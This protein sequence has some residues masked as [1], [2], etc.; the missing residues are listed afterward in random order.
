MG[1]EM[2]CQGRRILLPSLLLLI[3]MIGGVQATMK[4]CGRKLPETLSKLCVYGFNAMTKRTL[5]AVNF[6]LID[7]FEDRSLLERLLSDSSVQ[8]LKTRRL[9]DGVF[10]ECCLKSCTMDEVLRYCAAKPRTITS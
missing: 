10:D 3:L 9:R 7:G 1:I 4:L 8:M 6:N 5:D 2:R